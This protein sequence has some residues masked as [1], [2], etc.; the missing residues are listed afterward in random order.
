MMALVQHNY[1]RLLGYHAV[2]QVGYMVTGIGL[3]TILGIVGGLFH[4]INHALYKSG[5][6]LV[7]GGI[8]KQTGR[9]NLEKLGGLSKQM[10]LTFFGALIFALSISGIPPLNGFASKWMIYQGIIDFGHGASLA[11]KLWIVWLALAVIG[12]ALTLASF[13]KFISG[14]FLGRQNPE[15]KKIKEVSWLMWLPILLL[16][17]TCIGFGI[18]ASQKVIPGLFSPIAG[19]FKYTGLW[20]SS[21]ISLLILISIVLGVLI[22]LVFSISRFRT[23]DS[24]IGG[25]TQREQ[26]GYSPTE[27]YD[28]IKNSEFFRPLYR[29]AE[30]KRFDIYDVSKN[31]V[32]KIS[33]LFSTAHNGILSNLAFWVLAGLIF[34]FIF[35]LL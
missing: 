15:L 27:F 2:S 32:L 17:L 13:I 33:H 1:K 35:L 16:A 24:F 28:T 30:K 9:D 34:M 19:T 21:A 23:D 14:V 18:F 29:A 11:S 25:E 8:K 6:F 7:A 22:Y 31:I 5:L 3:G 12:S 26:A 4:M 10:P 20:N